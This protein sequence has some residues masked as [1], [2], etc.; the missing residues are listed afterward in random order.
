MHCEVSKG[1][2]SGEDARARRSS[3]GSSAHTADGRSNQGRC[4][5]TPWISPRCLGRWT[6]CSLISLSFE[7]AAGEVVVDDAD[8]LEIRIDDRGAHEREAPALALLAH[9][10]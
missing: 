8:R 10:L 4:S 7:R 3:G 5:S 9:A 6:S 2:L 1:S